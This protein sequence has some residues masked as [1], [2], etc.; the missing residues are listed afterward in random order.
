M[1]VFHL[2]S[3]SNR[4]TLNITIDDEVI[5][6]TDEHPFLVVFADRL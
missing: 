3:I 5:Y 6:T 1:A 2:L 4:K